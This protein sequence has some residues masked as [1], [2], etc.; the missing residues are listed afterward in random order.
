[1]GRWC[2][3]CW[4]GCDLNWR[5]T[6]IIH[7][8]EVVLCSHLL[9]HCTHPRLLQC[10][11]C[12]PDWLELGVELREAWTLCF[13]RVGR[14]TRGCVGGISSLWSHDVDCQHGVWPNAR[15]P[16]RILNTC[17]AAIHVC[18]PNHWYCDG[19]H[20]GTA[21]FLAFLEGFCSWRPKRA[22]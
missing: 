19:L 4:L 13:Q 11:W 20:Y 22:I 17:V 1:M 8:R 7:P 18:E 10:I 21:H 16:D 14:C 2:W 12:R 15:F 5:G 9:P 3:L 6:P